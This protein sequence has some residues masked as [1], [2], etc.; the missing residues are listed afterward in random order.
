MRKRDGGECAEGGRGRRQEIGEQ[1]GRHTDLQGAGSESG[2]GVG[3]QFLRG[4]RNL[5]L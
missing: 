1:C 5:P 3:Q 4:K 2:L